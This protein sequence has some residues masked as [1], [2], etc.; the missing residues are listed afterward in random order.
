MASSA[1]MP[2]H[3]LERRDLVIDRATEL[4]LGLLQ[5]ALTIQELAVASFEHLR[6]LIELLVALDQ[7]TF[8]RRELAASGAGLLFGLAAEPQLLV[9]RLE[10]ELLLAGARLRFDA[11]SFRLR[12]LH[13]LG[14]PHAAGQC[15]E[16]GSADGGQ[17]GHRHEDRCVHRLSSHPDRIVRPDASLVRWHDRV[18]G[19]DR[20]HEWGRA[21]PRAVNSTVRGPFRWD[22]IGRF[23]VR[24]RH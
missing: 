9:L 2:R 11:A 7:T 13:A 18:W 3:P 23:S 17:Y 16:Y 19:G 15:A 5:L 14:C 8:L 21:R 12:R 22:V 6:A 24:K 1:A 10:D 20:T 4:L